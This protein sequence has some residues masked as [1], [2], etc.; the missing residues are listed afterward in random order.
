MI[1][2]LYKLKTNLNIKFRGTPRLSSFV[3]H[4]TVEEGVEETGDQDVRLTVSQLANDREELS[5]GCSISETHTHSQVK[6]K[7]SNT[8]KWDHAFVFLLVL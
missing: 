8:N 4:S 6:T 7:N 1:F 3:D 2:L 5:A